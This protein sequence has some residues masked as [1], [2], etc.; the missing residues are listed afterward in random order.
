MSTDR[1]LRSF[2][3]LAGSEVLRAEPLCGGRNARVWRLDLADGRTLAG[4]CYPQ[5]PRRDRLACEVLALDFL[6]ESGMGRAPKLIAADPDERC[7]LMEYVSGRTPTATDLL[8]RRHGPDLLQ[9]MADFLADLRQAWL[10]GPG[11]EFP[12]ASEA[13]LSGAAYEQAVRH[14]LARLRAVADQGGEPDLAAFLD[15]LEPE[16]ELRAAEL[17]AAL[18][19]DFEAE[20]PR[21][22]R[23]ASPSD[24]GPHNARLTEKGLVFLD[25]EYFGQDD[26]AKLLA[27]TLLH[28]GSVG[29]LP[30]EAVAD[31]RVRLALALGGAEVE[32][33][34]GLVLPLTGLKWCLILLNEF[35]DAGL[36]RREF[37]A[38]REID[39]RTARA[40][41]L[42][43]ARNMLNTVRAMPRQGDPA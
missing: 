7:L 2:A 9:A 12:T 5:D 10:D 43:K 22:Q 3:D 19:P 24:F 31:L 40:E 16:L 8:D 23:T 4:K 42:A 33:R 1:L 11:L 25:F 35:L 14:R 20:L 30:E 38:D 6:E 37:A 41:Q 21:E 36:A 17:R 28:P 18:G 29:D 26:P 34:A 15:A 32:R 27:D 13:C 39:P